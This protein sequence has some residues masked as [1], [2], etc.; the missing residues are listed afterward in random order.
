[1]SKRTLLQITLAAAALV[2]TLPEAQVYFWRDMRNVANYENSSPADLFP[3]LVR[4]VVAM[5]EPPLHL[6]F[7][8]DVELYLAPTLA[9]RHEAFAQGLAEGRHT[10]AWVTS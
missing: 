2:P 6:P 7:G 9:G 4:K 3:L 1:M 10:A 8:R 5:D